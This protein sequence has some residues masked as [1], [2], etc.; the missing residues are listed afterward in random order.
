MLLL[1]VLA[2]GGLIGWYRGVRAL[3]S[4][5]LM[6]VVAY[7]LFVRGGEQL[8]AVVNRILNLVPLF[9]QA[10]TGVGTGFALPTLNINL[11]LGPLLSLLMFFFLAVFIPWLLDRL[12]FPGWYSNAPANNSERYV[13]TAAGLL[14]AGLFA[15]AAVA[16][17]QDFIAAGVQPVA[18]L[19]A[20][21]GTA[22]IILPDIGFFPVFGLLGLLLVM[23]VFNLPR[24]WLRR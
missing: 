13:G 21:I 18:A 22:L 7:P 3:I 23:L 6:S 10:L 16:F 20:F 8:Q 4:I 17:T 11:G 2:V 9:V 24:I 12:G 5:S 14:L 15:S 1:F 19:G